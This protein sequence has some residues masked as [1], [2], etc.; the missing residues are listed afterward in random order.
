[1][2]DKDKNGPKNEQIEETPL[3]QSHYKVVEPYADSPYNKFAEADLPILPEV[4]AAAEE[5]R[6][7]V[8]PPVA[9][10]A[11]KPPIETW[12]ERIRRIKKNPVVLYGVAGLGLGVLLVVLFAIVSSFL[13]PPDGRYDLGPVTSDAAGLNGRMFLQWDKKLQYR[14]TLE[15]NYPDQLA[16]FSAAVTSSQQPLSVQI[17]LLDIKGFVLCSKDILLKYNARDE[18][19]APEAQAAQEAA[20]ERGR[21]VFENQTGPDGRITAINAHGDLPCS[22]KAYEKALSWSFTTNFP[23]L[24]DQNELLKREKEPQSKTAHPSAEEDAEHKKKAAKAQAKLLPFSV[25]GDDAIV[26][27]DAFRGTIVTRGRKTFFVDKTSPALTNTRWQDYP[28]AIH[29]R[30]DRSAECTL[31]N[32][33]AG[34]MHARLAR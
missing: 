11:A 22:A 29:Y 15:P 33:G 7:P 23:S 2:T 27:L 17:N 4:S 1:M 12:P 19:L 24:A 31:M 32:S 34:A 21:D 8:V 10:Q 9:P 14:M 18:Q 5:P 28:V 30:C 26:D 13:G 25:E 6:P 3:P 16:E 20:R